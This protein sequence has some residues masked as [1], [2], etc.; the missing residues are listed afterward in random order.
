MAAGLGYKEFLTG[1]VLTAA[2]ANGY[3]ASQVVMVF[4]SS[5][6]RASAITSPQE[7]MITYLKDTDVTQYY[8]GSA[9]VTIGGSA[10]PLTTKGD[11]YGFSTTNARVAVGTNG[12][13]L[14]ADSTAATGVA[15]ATPAAAASGLTLISSESFSAVTS[16]SINNCFSATYQ[17]Y[18]IYVNITS[19]TGGDYINLKL[20]VSATDSSAS[21][22]YVRLIAG[23]GAV[24]SGDT[25]SSTAGYQIGTSTTDLG[26][27]TRIDCYNPA[28]ARSTYFYSIG[29]RKNGTS[30]EL[31]STVGNHDVA[32]A[33]DGLTLIS[34]GTAF[35]G[36]IR[37]Y[38]VQ[39][40]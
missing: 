5:A 36:N 37:V 22:N 17:N 16:K 3:L 24:A 29:N 9:Y 40:A 25:D 31:E 1:D 38:G 10:S 28:L 14:T 20:R 7:G 8:S 33:Y 2:D 13:L 15:W 27:A 39:N 11:L 6:A 4:A 35:A 12:Q 32:T 23:G 34:A 26:G 30:I 21:Y 18:M 19:A